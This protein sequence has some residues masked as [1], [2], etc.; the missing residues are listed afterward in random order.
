[1]PVAIS[2]NSE[3]ANQRPTEVSF[4][5]VLL[6]LACFAGLIAALNLALA[7][8]AQNGFTGPEA[9]VTGQ[10]MM[11]AHDGRLYYDL[12]G[13]PYTVCAYTPVFYLLEGGLYKLGLPVY[14]PGRILSFCAFLGI[15]F[16][17]RR[18]ILLYTRDRLCANLAAL[19]CASSALLVFWGTVGQVDILAVFFSLAAF[20]S[21]SRYELRQESALGWAALF[22][23]LAFFTKQT[24]LACPAAIT[25]LLVVERPKAAMRFAA[26]VMTG[27]VVI[28][29]AI[30]SGTSGAFFR[31][32]VLAN[33]NPFSWDKL[34][35][36]LRYL[37]WVAGPILLVVAA[38]AKAVIR[39]SGR[40]LL[41]YLGLALMVFGVTAPKIGSDL[42]YQIEGMVLLILCACTA[43]H[44]LDFLP[45]MFAGSKSWVTLLQLPVAVFLVVNYGVGLRDVVVRFATEQFVR[46]EIAALR[47]YML[48]SGRVLVADYNALVRLRGRI[49]LEMLI[50]KVLADA[51]VV[52][53]VP[54][55]RDISRQ[56]FSAIVLMQDVERDKSDLP[57]EVSTLTRTQIDE[58]RKHYRLV[59]HIPGPMLDGLYVFQPADGKVN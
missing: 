43:L 5:R 23:I 21:Y 19:M 11:L 7:L 22:A 50:Y 14:I 45:A 34:A 31:N 46:P 56:T 27:V 26:A 17:S 48:D 30:N 10:S 37:L 13:Y 38:G 33:L 41:V 32:T 55:E 6:I 15:C 35:S 1:M 59:K 29:L 36:H 49:D 4:R 2:P 39:S 8:W 9:V 52:D 12:R 3:L 57:V 47:P 42:N 24:M 54:V 20:Y 40:A 25:L 51:R 18:L 16:L 44:S 53:P 28:A 58:V